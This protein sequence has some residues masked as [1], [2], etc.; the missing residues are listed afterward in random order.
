MI[1]L[2]NAESIA[3]T[4]RQRWANY[5]TILAA[6]IGIGGGM[7]LRNQ[8]LDA[9][10]R[11]ENQTVGIIAR[12]PANWLLEE[13]QEPTKADFVFRV[14]DPESIPFKTALQVSLLIVGPGAH[15][16]DIPDLLNM[17]RAGSFSAYRPLEIAQITLPDGT[18]GIQ[19]HYAYVS[20]ET[21][22]F[23]QSVPIVVEALD[24]IAVKKN[25]NQ[26]VVITFRSDSQF[27]EQNRHYFD[28]FLKS[29]QY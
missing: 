19:M 6:F 14:Q 8:N 2:L 4:F 7:L 16:A 12:Y 18:S 15:P 3:L 10:N 27:F 21:N 17:T 11:Y 24:V 13:S 23:L 28:N 25:S 29:L 20:S 9:T 26:A 1:S 5:L 22:Q